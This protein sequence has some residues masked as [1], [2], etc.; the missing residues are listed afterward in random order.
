MNHLFIYTTAIGAA[1]SLGRGTHIKISYLLDKTG[2]KTR[3]TIVVIN[4]LLMI[5]LNA[6]MIRYSLPWIRST[7]AFMSP[8]L[9]IPSW[10]VQISVPV[11]CALAIV[12][13]GLRIRREIAGPAAPSGDE[14][15]KGA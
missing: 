5:L 7:G 8:V 15:K 13:C 3:K 2:G 14:R 11:G 6:V 4:L 10:T 9:Q 1:V 12:Y